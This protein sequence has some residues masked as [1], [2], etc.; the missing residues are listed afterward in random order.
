MFCFLHNAFELG[1]LA[2]FLCVFKLI[3]R[4]LTSGRALQSPL[5][6]DLGS[7]KLMQ[8]RLRCSQ[9]AALAPADVRARV[10]VALAL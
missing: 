10:A 9:T 2:V 7:V 8:A 4:L 6:C 3:D 5:H 1:L